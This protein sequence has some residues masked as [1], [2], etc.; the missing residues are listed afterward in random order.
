MI[1]LKRD[2]PRES[3][4][5]DRVLLFVSDDPKSRRGRNQIAA[6]SY[7]TKNSAGA[8]QQVLLAPQYEVDSQRQGQ[9]NRER[10]KR[11]HPPLW[12]I[13]VVSRSRLTAMAGWN[14]QSSYLR[15]RADRL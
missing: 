14:L 4:F 6:R 15:R 9:V 11:T 3:Y 8:E 7:A 1:F 13:V 12:G 5:I 10:P 2:T